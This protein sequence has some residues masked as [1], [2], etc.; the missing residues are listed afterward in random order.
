MDRQGGATSWCWMG[1][2]FVRARGIPSPKE[3]LT[4]RKVR[5]RVGARTAKQRMRVACLIAAGANVHGGVGRRAVHEEVAVEPPPFVFRVPPRPGKRRRGRKQ[6]HPRR[7]G[8]GEEVGLHRGGLR[9]TRLALLPEAHPAAPEPLRW[10]TG[11]SNS[12]NDHI[13]DFSPHPV[14]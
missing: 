11:L 13:A 12:G 2:L 3:F 7:F 9:T 5:M 8:R 4:A 6:A 1:N 10:K 14:S